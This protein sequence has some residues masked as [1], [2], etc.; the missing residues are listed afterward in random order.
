MQDHDGLFKHKNTALATEEAKKSLRI[1]TVACNY[2]AELG[3]QL[4]HMYAYA[5]L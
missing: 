2:Y 4:V 5:I 1:I 3:T